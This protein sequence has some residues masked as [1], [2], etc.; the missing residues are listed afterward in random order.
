[1]CRRKDV[2]DTVGVIH[3]AGRY[4]LTDK[5]FLNEGADQILALGSRVIKVWFYSGKASEGHRRFLPVQF[6]VAQGRI[7]SSKGPRRRTS[8]SSS[9][10]RSP[11]TS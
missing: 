7:R 1:M 2:R 5:D 11:P 10:S 8:R 4:H 6:P 9:T 3:V